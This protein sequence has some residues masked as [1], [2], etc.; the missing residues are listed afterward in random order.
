MRVLG[1]DGVA[2]GGLYAAGEVVGGLHGAGYLV[3]SALGKAAVFG[4]VAGR[5]AASRGG[6]RR[7][8]REEQEISA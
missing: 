4:M 7:S 8:H 2:I 6:R 3:G 1:D 5:A